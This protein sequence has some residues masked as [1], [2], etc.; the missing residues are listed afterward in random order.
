MPTLTSHIRELAARPCGTNT[1]EVHDLSHVALKIVAGAM[2]ELLR[3]GQLFKVDGQ[4]VGQRLTLQQ[5][6]TSKQDADAWVVRPPMQRQNQRLRRSS[7]NTTSGH[8]QRSAPPAPTMVQ[9]PTW[10]TA[11]RTG[12]PESKARAPIVTAGP[13]APT[14]DSRYCVDPATF[15]G[16]ELSG[17]GIGHYA[18]DASTWAASAASR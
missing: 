17:L 13:Q 15:A 12:S 10:Q 6:F 1:G 3:R 9:R 8:R 11:P 14:F 4:R 2:H 7:A 18:T 16:G 5:F